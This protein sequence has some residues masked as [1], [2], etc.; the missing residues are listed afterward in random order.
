MRFA[1]SIRLK[2]GVW[3]VDIVELHPRALFISLS[4]EAECQESIFSHVTFRL[5]LSLPLVNTDPLLVL[6]LCHALSLLLSSNFTF[7]SPRYKE[8]QMTGHA[9]YRKEK[10]VVPLLKF[11]YFLKAIGLHQLAAVSQGRNCIIVCVCMCVRER[12]AN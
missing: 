3:P 11:R 6:L 7:A 4:A 12:E 2:R 5:S 8:A 10:G 9:S 1:R